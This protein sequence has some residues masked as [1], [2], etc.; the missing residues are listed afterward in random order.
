M[1]SNP[2]NQL[3]LYYQMI[4]NEFIKQKQEKYNSLCRNMFVTILK[5]PFYLLMEEM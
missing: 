2:L 3:A 5:R 4:Q 1:S